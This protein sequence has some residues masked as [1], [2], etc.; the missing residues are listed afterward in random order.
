M[1]V[2]KK[3]TQIDFT[4]V[5]LCRPWKS[6]VVRKLRGPTTTGPLYRPSPSD[7]LPWNDEWEHELDELHWDDHHNGWGRD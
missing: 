5:K 2:R 6:G 1:A 7:G 3:L 4:N